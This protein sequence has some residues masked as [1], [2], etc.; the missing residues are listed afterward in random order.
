MVLK[1][2]D[3]AGLLTV[4]VLRRA[5]GDLQSQDRPQLS[6][7]LGMRV[8]D[9]ERPQPLLE[10]VRILPLRQVESRVQGSGLDSVVAVAGPRDGDLAE[11][12][13]IRT[14]EGSIEPGQFLEWI[15]GSR[16]GDGEGR[17]DVAGAG[18]VQE[19]LE[20]PA[21]DHQEVAEE[22]L[23][24]LMNRSLSVG[25]VL[26]VFDDVPERLESFIDA[27]RARR[28]L[29]CGSETELDGGAGGGQHDCGSSSLWCVLGPA[30]SWNI[31]QE[32]GLFEAPSHQAEILKH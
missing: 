13:Q 30:T 12:R 10:Q 26:H 9:D 11:D 5:D 18:H 23:L 2:L 16:T 4:E 25:G 14:R 19:G 31:P 21:A 1:H 29:G 28:L 22:G 7:R 24:D 27:L 20:Q 6:D 8:V 3:I 15:S 32:E 17:T